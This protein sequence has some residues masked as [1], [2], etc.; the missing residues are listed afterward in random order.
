MY[1]LLF[2]VLHEV[3]QD[4]S[5]NFLELQVNTE[6]Y[7]DTFLTLISIIYLNKKTQDLPPGSR[8]LSKFHIIN[9]PITFRYP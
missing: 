7:N 3:S 9:L 5:S 8:Q 1:Y 4:E 2:I 6:H